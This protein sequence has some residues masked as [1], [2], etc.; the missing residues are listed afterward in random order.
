MA[1]Y[2]TGTVAV[3]QGSLTVTGSTVVE[4]GGITNEH[5]FNVRGESKIYGIST[6][7]AEAREITLT[8]PYLGVPNGAVEY[9]LTV[10][11]TPHFK[12]P[13]LYDGDIAIR[14]LIN[15]AS[16]IIDERLQEAGFNGG[17]PLEAPYLLFGPDP[18]LPNQRQLQVSG[19]LEVSDGGTVLTLA[20]LY[21]D[22]T[23]AV[24]GVDPTKLMTPLTTAEALVALLDAPEPYA[25]V[26]GDQIL[27]ATVAPHRGML[28]HTGGAA[29]WTLPA[30]IASSGRIRVDAYNLG[31]GALTLSSSGPAQA[32]LTSLA[33]GAGAR[34]NWVRKVG[35]TERVVTV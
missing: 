9:A 29:I 30:R 3:S 1:Q 22:Q 26:T 25:E 21:A 19:A 14:G 31:S 34:I 32:G 23:E 15:E 5:L 33:V 13:L 10:D 2:R 17:A 28:V 11:L 6:V 27:S 12:L 7:D 4:W 8:T 18:V 24:L 35:G 16:V 20:L